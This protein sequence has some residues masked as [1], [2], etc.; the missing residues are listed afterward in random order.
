MT[1][2]CESGSTNSMNGVVK[3]RIGLDCVSSS[4]R[5]YATTKLFRCFEYVTLLALPGK[6][7]RRGIVLAIWS[8]VQINN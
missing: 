8:K 1:G 6:E 2:C 5:V 7:I 3:R 4:V